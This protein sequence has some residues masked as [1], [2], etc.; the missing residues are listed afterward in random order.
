[1]TAIQ[2]FTSISHE[3]YSADLQATDTCCRNMMLLTVLYGLSPNKRR[4]V[5]FLSSRGLQRF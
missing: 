1:M 2:S 3:L 5:H 4:E